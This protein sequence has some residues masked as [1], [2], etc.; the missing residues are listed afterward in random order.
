M[1]YCI[2]KSKLNVRSRKFLSQWLS[3]LSHPIEKLME[4]LNIRE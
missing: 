1:Y 4:L 2:T 3:N